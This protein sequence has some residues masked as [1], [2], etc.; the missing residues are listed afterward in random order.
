MSTLPAGTFT[1]EVI[2]DEIAPV[3]SALS[4]QGISRSAMPEI[5]VAAADELS[6]I[7]SI[8]ISVMNSAGDA[9]EGTAAMGEGSAT[10]EPG[11]PLAND[12]YTASTVV[13][14][15][16]GNVSTASWSFVVEVVMDVAPPAI[17]TTSPSGIVRIA[18]PTITASATDDLSGVASI[19]ISLTAGDGSAVDGGS[20]FDGATMAI[21]T[22]GGELA[23]DTYTATAVVTDNAGNE[24]KGSWS[25]TVEVVTDTTPPTISAYSPQGLVR[26]D[27]PMVTVSA[28]DDMSGVASIEIAVSNS[29]GQVGGAGSFDAGIGTFAPARDLGNDTYTVNAVVADNAGNTA[30]AEW[31][32]T[33]EADDTEPVIGA[34]SPQGIVR[35]DTPRLTVSATDGI[36]GIASIEIRLLGPGLAPVAGNT[37]YEG[38][39]SAAFVPANGLANGTYSAAVDV[40]DK[41]GNTA[42]ASWSFTLEADR[43]APVIN[44]TSPQ[45]TIRSDTPRVSVA[46]TDDLSGIASIEIR[47]FNSALVRVGGPTVFE[48]GTRAHFS[49][50]NPLRNDT[51]TVGVDVTDKAGN[52][53]NASWSFTVQVDTTPPVISANSPLG[54]VRDEM[55]ANQRERHR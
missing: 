36:S 26:N 23:N 48:G 17:G 27:T 38:G 54:I 21:F 31:T 43:A 9:V 34:L 39:T 55:P 12:T 19:D 46:A 18:M 40:T 28:T 16:S 20:E 15:N 22:P 51:Y 11:A 35:T 45:G 25:F 8:D 14:D 53:T 44:T 3:I 47:V 32:F 30:S 1:V 52:E 49:P 6:G 24:T 10:F 7:G 4:P 41:A 37:I 33:L 13:T 2:R 42:N 29:N 5:S 50:A